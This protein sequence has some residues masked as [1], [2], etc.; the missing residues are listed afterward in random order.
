[1]Y[2]PRKMVINTS[3]TKW[4][5]ESPQTINR[6]WPKTLLKRTWCH[7]FRSVYD[8]HQLGGHLGRASTPTNAV[9]VMRNAGMYV[10]SVKLSRTA[11]EHL[12][13]YHQGKPGQL[14]MIRRRRFGWVP[15]L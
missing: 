2:I 6:A 1:M 13:P 4:C 5:S 11:H 10:R 7:P 14:D 8:D 15:V 9:L 3:P 12:R